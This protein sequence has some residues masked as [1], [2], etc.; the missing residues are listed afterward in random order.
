MQKVHNRECG[1]N[2]GPLNKLRI[3]DLTTI[4]M[5]PYATQ[6]LG[7]FGADVIK[8]EAPEG[9]VT[10]QSRPTKSPEMG[11]AFLNTNRSKRAVTLDLKTKA[12]LKAL[13]ALVKTADVFVTNVRPLALERLGL[14]YEVLSQ[15]NPR[16]IY[17]SLVGYA[18]SGP[19]AARPAYDD[20]IQGAAGVAYSFLRATGSPAYIPSAMADRVA[21]LATVNALLAAVVERERS[22]QGQKVEVPM[23][24]TMVAIVMGDHM[25]GLT[26]DPPLDEG[27]NPRHLSPNRC[28]YATRD[29]YICILIYNDAQ[30]RRFFAVTGRPELPDA[31]PRFAS[32]S[33]RLAHIDE[34]Y[35]EL[36]DTIKSRST[37]EWLDLFEKA[38]I[39][40][41]PL[42][43]YASLLED[44]HLKATGYFERVEHPTEGPLRQ[45]KVAATFSRTPASVSR[46]A[47][48]PNEHGDEL[49]HEVGFSDDE[50]RTFRGNGAF[51]PSDAAAQDGASLFVGALSEEA[52]VP[53]YDQLLGSGGGETAVG[54]KPNAS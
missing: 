23:F 41:M 21:G 37:A 10:R 8:V 3:V 5:G 47:P 38:D 1:G 34:I 11:S 22:G 45:M 16:L 19:Y 27:G 48:L 24:E 26:Y 44:E 7:D 6:I 53:D 15:V 2:M 17:T 51:G 13:L 36:A 20:L 32:F 33:V 28:P 49:M 52:R 43:S 54:R 40:A 25:G 18:Q 39:P 30:W 31:D 29:G 4:L 14:G 50:I 35:S 46:P 42:H 12:G 9:D